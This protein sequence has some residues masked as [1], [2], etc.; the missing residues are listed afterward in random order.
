MRPSET[1][2]GQAWLSNFV[3]PDIPTATVLLDSLRFVSLTQLRDGL[4]SRLKDL[5]ERRQLPA[6]AVVLPERGMKDFKLDREHQKAPVAYCDFHPGEPIS[7][8]PGSE[9]FVGMVL[10][11]LPG[12]R[13]L[14]A[15]PDWIPPNKSLDELRDLRC[16]SIVLVTDYIG[17][18]N[19]VLTLAAALLRNRRI[20]SWR[21]FH[22]VD[23]YVVAFAASPEAIARVHD[24]PQVSE[25]W[26]V[27]G[28]P[29]LESTSWPP[30]VH[31]RR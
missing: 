31:T 4:A 29:T 7:A 15:D 18:G 9:A 30:E 14:E 3:G 2:P 27:E 21:S 16:R 25:A 10:R 11:D 17:T 20:R 22:W 6:P 28:A 19:R 5:I 23:V 1:Q 13:R 8:T 26:S 24:S 12:I